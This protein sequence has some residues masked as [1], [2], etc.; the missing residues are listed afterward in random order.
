MHEIDL[1]DAEVI[2][3]PFAAYGRVREESPLARLQAIPGIDPWWVVTRHEQARA[4]LSDPRFEIRSDSFMRP[5]VPDDCL[6]YM[7]TMSEM[8][9][10]EHARMRK[11]VAPA[12]TPRRATDFRQRIESI[13]EGLLDATE[14]QASDGTVDLLP[15]FTRPLPMDVICEWVGIP[16]SDRMRWRT[17][18]ATVAGGAGPDFAMAIPGIMDGAKAA[19]AHRRDDPGDDLLTDLITAQADDGDRLTDTEM[20]TLVWHLVMAGQTPTN[21]IANAVLALLAHPRQRELLRDDPDLMPGA[22]EE[23]MRWCGPT[24]LTIPRYT[25]EDTELCGTRV[26]EGQSVV[27]S[28]AAANRDPRVFNDPDELDVTRP[29]GENPHLGFAHGPHFCLGASMARVQTQVALNALLRRYPDLT[30][31][32]TPDELRAPCLL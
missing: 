9:G 24:L 11:L 29:K 18:G 19:I 4:M 22:V 8:N 14:A 17:Y 30:L 26:S 6:P 23:L 25:R 7:R 2:R 5:D 31:A 3:N 21:L 27:A 20:V 13:V 10:Q 32:S 15:H 28:V 16:E 1:T 12:F